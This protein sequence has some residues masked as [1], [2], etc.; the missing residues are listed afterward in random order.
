MRVTDGLDRIPVLDRQ[1]TQRYDSEI[2]DTAN[3]MR[4]SFTLR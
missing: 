3:L 1:G 4:W 2:E